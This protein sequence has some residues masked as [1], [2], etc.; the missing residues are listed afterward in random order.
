MILNSQY[1]IKNF[2]NIQKKKKIKISKIKIIIF[3]S[4]EYFNQQQLFLLYY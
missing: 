4:L 2:V 3:V 1:K